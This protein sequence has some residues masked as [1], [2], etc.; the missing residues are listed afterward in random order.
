[1][2][3]RNLIILVLLSISAAAFSQT[4][5]KLK[6]HCVMEEDNDTIYYKEN[7]MEAEMTIYKDS[8]VTLNDNGR[9]VDSIVE[10][11]EPE[12]GTGWVTY[13]LNNPDLGII[14]LT[15]KH[16][17]IKLRMEI[18]RHRPVVYKVLNYDEL[19]R[20]VEGS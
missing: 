16:D 17:R 9:F 12:P 19:Y 8:I 2:E 18:D 4:T 10:V 11:G 14:W 6:Y 20:I 7:G 3:M 15:I 13:T 1:M 5:Y